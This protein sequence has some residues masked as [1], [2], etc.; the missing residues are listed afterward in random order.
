MRRFT[1]TARRAAHKPQIV[2]FLNHVYDTKMYLIQFSIFTFKNS[3]AF[4][5]SQKT[6]LALFGKYPF[7]HKKC[8]A[9]DLEAQKNIKN[10]LFEI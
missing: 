5:F 1:S 3:L 7:L 4:Y 6:S 9:F 10:T 8:S 2:L